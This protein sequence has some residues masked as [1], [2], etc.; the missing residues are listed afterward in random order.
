MGHFLALDEYMEELVRGIKKLYNPGGAQ[1]AEDFSRTVSARCVAHFLNV[2]KQI[3]REFGSRPNS[4]FHTNFDES[5][6]VR[7]LA[8]RLLAM[9]VGEL[10]IGR[11]FKGWSGGVL[12]EKKDV[13]QEGLDIL[14]EGEY[15][16]N[17]VLRSPLYEEDDDY[18]GVLDEAMGE[19]DSDSDDEGESGDAEQAS[20]S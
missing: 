3:K 9:R 14:S 7:A 11:G 19:I 18:G 12:E 1:Q 8:E 4:N 5:V 6:D 16:R 17:F 10:V 13:M 15:W 20:E 2:K